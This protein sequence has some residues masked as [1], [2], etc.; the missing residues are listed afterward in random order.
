[1]DIV[2][3]GGLYPGTIKT[4]K[5]YSDYADVDSVVVSCWEHDD[6]SDSDQEILEQTDN[7]TVLGN[8]KPDYLGPG[9]LNLH[10]LSTQN[11]IKETTS[12][13]VMKIR[14][15]QRLYHSAFQRWNEYVTEGLK[16]T[17]M[18]Y[19]GDGSPKGKVFVI[20]MNYEKPYHPQ[21]HIFWGH[22][23]DVY[24]VFDIP[25]SNEP[26]LPPEKNGKID[27]SVNSGNLRNPIY[28]GMH[29]FAK[30]TEE[31]NKHTEN[32][33]EYL[34]D[35]APKW[36][37]ALEHYEGIRDSIFKILPRIDDCMLWEKFNTGYWYDVYH[38]YGERYE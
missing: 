31:A 7:I 14:S 18:S 17:P 22:K 29:Y 16:E 30:F 28:I 20:G 9:N 2:M 1:M 23:E 8:V 34:L 25:F 38:R 33:K 36:Q 24:S 5:L 3:Q 32:Y 15:D 27:F 12:D 13:I 35:N 4:A 37:E 6:I 10:L 11:G 26:P 21:D 19:S